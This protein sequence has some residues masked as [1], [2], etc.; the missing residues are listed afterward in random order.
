MMA[1]RPQGL[2]PSR[3]RSAEIREHSSGSSLGAEVADPR[4]APVEVP[5]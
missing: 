3:R 2:L 1:L 5:K 4:D